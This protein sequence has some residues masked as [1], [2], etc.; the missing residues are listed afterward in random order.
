[1]NNRV[2]TGNGEGVGEFKTV[3][4]AVMRPGIGEGE[5]VIIGITVG[6]VELFRSGV[7]DSSILVPKEIHAGKE[8]RINKN[9]DWHR[10]LDRFTRFY[11]TRPMLLLSP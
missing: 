9:K 10:S 7:G 6:V 2:V 11:F 4:L 8:T 1:V 3:G 5:V